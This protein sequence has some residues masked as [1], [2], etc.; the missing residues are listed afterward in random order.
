MENASI[1]Q[2]KLRQRL[3]E[4]RGSNISSNLDNDTAFKKIK[5]KFTFIPKYDIYKDLINWD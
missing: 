2:N 3:Q 5:Q 1:L 4:R